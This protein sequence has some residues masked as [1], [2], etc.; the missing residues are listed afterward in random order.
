MTERERLMKLI[1]DMPKEQIVP[2]MADYLLKNGVT[3]TDEKTA[4]TI[5]AE[6]ITSVL[7]KEIEKE[8]LNKTSEYD[9]DYGYCPNCNTIMCDYREIY[10]CGR[11]GQRIDWR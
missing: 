4:L 10:R 3:I 11:C 1:S 6:Y 5:K 8:P 9:G 7:E 2:E